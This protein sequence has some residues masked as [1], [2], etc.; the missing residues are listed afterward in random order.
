MRI[1]SS[2]KK[3]VDL[4]LVPTLLVFFSLKIRF[5]IIITYDTIDH[6]LADWE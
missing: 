6:L 5:V 3:T 2:V 1:E 4:L